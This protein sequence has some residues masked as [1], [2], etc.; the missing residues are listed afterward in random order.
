M[1][2][3][4]F[5]K[6]VNVQDKYTVVINAGR[7]HEVKVGEKFLLVGLGETIIDPDTQESLEQLEIIRGKVVVTHVQNKIATVKS[8]EVERTSDVKE[9]KKVSNKGNAYVAFMGAQDTVT[10]TIKPGEER[11]KPLENVNVGDMVI[12]L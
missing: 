4:Y 6:V 7:E 5:A 8:I 10:E 9:I 11:L 3:R 2:D 12:K 1:S